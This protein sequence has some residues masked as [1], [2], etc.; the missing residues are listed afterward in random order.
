MQLA[1]AARTAQQA[2]QQTRAGARR[3]PGHAPLHV[4][5]LP[6]L[7]L[8]SLVDVPGDVPFVVVKDKHLPIL[9]HPP[10]PADLDRVLSYNTSTRRGAAKGVRTSVHG[11]GQN[12]MD[13]II[14]GKA[15][16]N[17]NTPQGV[18]NI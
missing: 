12:L 15:P 9:A 6:D 1:S 16:N 5:I 7:P 8:I 3:S 18:V 13:G 10:H 2:R 4:R 17:C 14:H 11:I